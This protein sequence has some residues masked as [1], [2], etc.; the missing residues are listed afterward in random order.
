MK[1]DKAFGMVSK[2]GWFGFSQ[3]QAYYTK[4]VPFKSNKQ[5]KALEKKRA[6]KLKYFE[7]YYE[8]LIYVFNSTH[9]ND[10]DLIL[11]MQMFYRRRIQQLCA[12]KVCIYVVFTCLNRLKILIWVKL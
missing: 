1:H 10:H 5:L 12:N 6:K 2:R 11:Q 9:W 7:N 3:K 8:N 4:A